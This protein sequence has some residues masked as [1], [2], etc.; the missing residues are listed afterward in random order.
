[1]KMIAKWAL[2]L[3]LLMSTSLYISGRAQE[4]KPQLKPLK[5]YKLNA[6]KKNRVTHMASPGPELED[7]L[8]PST[9]Q[10]LRIRRNKNRRGDLQGKESVDFHPDLYSTLAKKDKDLESV[11]SSK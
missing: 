4:H 7:Q 11:H 9:T 10:V 3:V 6:N 2:S 1:M 8:Q 5:N